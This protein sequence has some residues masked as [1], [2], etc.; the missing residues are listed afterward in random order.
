MHVSRTRGIVIEHF[1]PRRRANARGFHLL[2]S[3]LAFL[4][5]SAVE[6][7]D[8]PGYARVRA[9]ATRFFFRLVRQHQK[10]KDLQE[11][12]HGSSPEDKRGPRGM[13]TFMNSNIPSAA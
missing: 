13:M 6:L 4:E 5:A 2:G 11:G 7:L 10:G 3:S 8:E 1:R 12:A 9:G